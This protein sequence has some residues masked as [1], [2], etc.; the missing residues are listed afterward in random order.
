MQI[1]FEEIFYESFVSKMNLN[2]F[3]NLLEYAK[4]YTYPYQILF[5]MHVIQKQW[6]QSQLW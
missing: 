2:G 4:D 1:V 3:K 5:H 6:S